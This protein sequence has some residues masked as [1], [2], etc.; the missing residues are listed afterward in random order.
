MSRSPAPLARRLFDRGSW[1]EARY[2]ASA[3]RTETVGAPAPRGG[4]PRPAV[5]QLPVGRRLL[6]A[7]RPAVGPAALHLDLTLA[8]WASDG[9][10]AVFFLVAGIELKREFTT[11][12]LAD[13]SRAVVPVVAAACGV[14]VRRCSSPSSRCWAAAARTSCAAGRCRP[15]PTSPSPSPCWRSSRRTCRRRCGPSCS[16][17]PSSTTSSPSRSSRLLHRRARGRAAAARDRPARP[18]HGDAAAR[19][20]PPRLAPAAAPPARARRAGS[21]PGPSSTPAGSTRRSR[22]CSWG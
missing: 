20:P 19:L 17:S 10:L 13:R 12:D 14:A 1:P 5:G 7:A 11:G 8:Q 6:F 2:V 16:P 22:A 9:L 18:L 15:R 21:P 4:R 3:L